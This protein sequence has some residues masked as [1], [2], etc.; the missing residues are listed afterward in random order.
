MYQHVDWMENFYNT[1][2][3]NGYVYGNRFFICTV[4]AATAVIAA[5]VVAATVVVCAV[6]ATTVVTAAIVAATVAVVRAVF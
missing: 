6:I 2:Q 1:K 4:N 5:T 3:T